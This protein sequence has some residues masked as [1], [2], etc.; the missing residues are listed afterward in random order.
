MLLL[1]YAGL[2]ATP[3]KAQAQ[4]TNTSSPRECYEAG[5]TQ[6]GAALGQF[7]AMQAEVQSLKEENARLRG[8]IGELQKTVAD[9]Q[10]SLV[11]LR[12]NASSVVLSQLKVSIVSLTDQGICI[13]M[14]AW[15]PAVRTCFE[16]GNVTASDPTTNFRR[17]LYPQ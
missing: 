14:P 12:T 13:H 16:N 1:T 8:A 15:S 7:R 10:K 17:T 6:V 4:C 9:T 5:L 2:L 3:S 11:D